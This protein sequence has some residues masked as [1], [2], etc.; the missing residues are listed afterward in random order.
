MSKNIVVCYDGTE[1]EYQKYNTN[2][3]RAFEVIKR[4]VS[5]VAFYDPGVGTF[6]FFGSYLGRWIRVLLGKAFGYGLRQNIEDGYEYL[7]DSFNTGDNVFIFGFSRGA[8]TA[9]SLAK[10]IHQFGILEKGSKNLIQYVLKMY[11]KEDKKKDF[12]VIE[13]FK[14]TFSHACKPRFIGLWDTVGALGPYLTRRIPDIEL[15][16]DI[17][18]V[19]HAIAI[20][21]KRITRKIIL[22]DESNKTDK[23]VIEQVWFPGTHSEVGGG[24][25]KGDCSLPDITLVWMLDKVS[26]C[27]LKL[28]SGW[29]NGFDQDATADMHDSYKFFPYIIPGLLKRRDIPRGAIIHQSVLDRMNGRDDYNPLLP[30]DKS[31]S[32]TNSYPINRAKGECV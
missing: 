27:G 12:S 6:S 25:S 29:Q 24:C 4:D 5:Q 30:T 20:D 7:M 9:C 23:Q 16:P 21:E 18:F 3:V 10:M 32:Y 19:F 8:Y 1:G 26:Q 28:K 11:F 22:L 2:I 15:N 13:G 14:K 17:K 31:I